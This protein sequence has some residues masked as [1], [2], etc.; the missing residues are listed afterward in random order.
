MDI[1]IIILISLV[2]I[3]VAVIINAAYTIRIFRMHDVKN[4]RGE[5]NWMFPS[6]V[7]ELQKQISDSQE[8]IVTIMN[9]I[10][11]NRERSDRLLE[12]LT[13]VVLE[14]HQRDKGEK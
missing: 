3:V 7:L 8:R 1:N 12:S 10:S 5:Y 9:G 6:S 4:E 14:L 11:Q 13:N 2:V